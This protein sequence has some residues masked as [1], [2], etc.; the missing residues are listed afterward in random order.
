M[1]K[2]K[3]KEINLGHFLGCFVLLQLKDEHSWVKSS[4]SNTPP[5]GEPLSISVVQLLHWGMVLET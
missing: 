5:L 1:A 3:E 2:S 4:L